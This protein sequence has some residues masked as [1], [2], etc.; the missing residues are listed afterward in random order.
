[1]SLITSAFRF[2]IPPPADRTPLTRSEARYF[3]VPAV[4]LVI[5]AGLARR[6]GTW[7]LRLALL[8]FVLVAILRGAFGFVVLGP[9]EEPVNHVF[10]AFLTLTTSNA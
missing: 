4:L 2:L 8:P 5:L 10:G 3:V 1:M 7:L 9:D 6:P